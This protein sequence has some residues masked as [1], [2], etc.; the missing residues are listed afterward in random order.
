MVKIKKKKPL[1]LPIDAKYN[2]LTNF[3]IVLYLFNSI[4]S[5]IDWSNR[6]HDFD[7]GICFPD[8]Y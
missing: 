4:F 8:T 5:I 1:S 6:L 3:L 7:E 2:F